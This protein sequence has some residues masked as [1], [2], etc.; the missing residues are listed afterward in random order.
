MD[1][2]GIGFGVGIGLD[3]FHVSAFANHLLL[4]VLLQK[5]TLAHKQFLHNLFMPRPSTIAAG[6]C[7][8]TCFPH[9]C[10]EAKLEK[11]GSV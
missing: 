4:S 2:V 10:R 3:I 1:G 6:G 9:L 5:C 11:A 7:C 8:E